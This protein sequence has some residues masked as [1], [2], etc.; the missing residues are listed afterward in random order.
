MDVEAVKERDLYILR[1]WFL[2][3]S[4]DS[5]ARGDTHYISSLRTANWFLL[6]RMVIGFLHWAPVSY[7]L[8]H[9]RRYL[10]YVFFLP[11]G[12]VG[13]EEEITWNWGGQELKF[14][15]LIRCPPE[16]TSSLLLDVC[17]DLIYGQWL[18]NPGGTQNHNFG[19]PHGMN[20]FCTALIWIPEIVETLEP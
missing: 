3:I 18:R 5:R 9:A 4:L 13:L 20:L 19:E 17:W 6:R 1:A 8:S 10:S 11:C 16:K 14:G 15:P 2:V 12:G 7:F